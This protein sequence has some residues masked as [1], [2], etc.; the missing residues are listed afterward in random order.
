MWFI[1]NNFETC[2][3]KIRVYGYSTSLQCEGGLHWFVVNFDLDFTLSDSIPVHCGLSWDNW[4]LPLCT[5]SVANQRSGR[6]AIDGRHSQIKLQLFS[7][8]FSIQTK[9]GDDSRI[10][11]VASLLVWPLGRQVVVLSFLWYSVHWLRV[12]DNLRILWG[13]NSFQFLRQCTR[14]YFQL[15]EMRETTFITV[16]T[17]MS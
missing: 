9:H 8:S 12:L 11:I 17:G 2:T 7:N 3:L 1:G 15:E 10:W 5:R 16:Q 4:D 14:N 13:E 6:N